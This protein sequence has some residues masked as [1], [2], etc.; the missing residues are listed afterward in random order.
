GLVMRRPWS[1]IISERERSLNLRG[2]LLAA[3]FALVCIALLAV[4]TADSSSSFAIDNRAVL[5]ALK[6]RITASDARPQSVAHADPQ[7][8]AVEPP[9]A[10]DA[11]AIEL[12]EVREVVRRG[13]TLGGILRRVGVSADEATRWSATTRRHASL[14]RLQLGHRFTFLLPS[15]SD[16]L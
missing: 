7:P 11:V 9:P 1:I 14:G 12:R 4:K 6:R 16:R 8:V 15:G 13:D 3:P 2:A 5:A 10:R